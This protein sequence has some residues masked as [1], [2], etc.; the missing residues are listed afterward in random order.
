LVVCLFIPLVMFFLSCALLKDTAEQK[1]TTK[2]ISEH[3]TRTE[4]TNLKNRLFYR[5]N[6]NFLLCNMM[7]LGLVT[8]ITSAIIYHSS[9]RSSVCRVV[10]LLE[11]L[12][13]YS[14]ATAEW[15]A[16]PT[17]STSSSITK[18]GEW[19]GCIA[20]S[21]LLLRTPIMKNAPANFSA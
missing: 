4:G 13:R 2:G 10:E 8:L 5:H 15:K 6:A 19:R 14:I 17:G 20:S 1:N 3:I 11:Y 16:A 7:D 18:Y 21:M 9:M 12:F